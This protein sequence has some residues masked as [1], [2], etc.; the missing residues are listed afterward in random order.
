VLPALIAKVDPADRAVV[1]A[2]VQWSILP[3]IRRRAQAGRDVQPSVANARR[4]IVEVIRFLDYLRVR[5]RSL[6]ACFQA[7]LDN[8][9]ALPGASRATVGPFLVWARRRRHLPPLTIRP[10]QRRT[11][12]RVTD[13]EDRWALARRLVNDDTLDEPDRFA[14]ALVVLYAQPLSR[15]VTLTPADIT[16][17]DSGI[18]VTLGADRIQ[19]PASLAD[20]ARRLPRTRRNGV[21]D[22]LSSRWL[23]PSGRA[24]QHIGAAAL[25]N[26]LR[27]IGVE[28]R[29]MRLAA[30]Y[31]LT[32][33]IPPALLAP[34]LG[35]SAGT[36]DRW[37]RLSRGDYAN[38]AAD[39][40][41]P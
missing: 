32:G 35:I 10:P 13:P 3:R 23:F 2:W 36:A 21:A 9:F 26:R 6:A 30:L 16:A 33:E 8:W 11:P 27:A 39:R 28:P 25:G 14:A 40:Q 15:I 5:G 37:S 22:Q 31:Q 41:E 20:I 18:Y 7:D 17:A 24:G 1:A 38:Y 12:A 4:L 34:M 29:S 19:L